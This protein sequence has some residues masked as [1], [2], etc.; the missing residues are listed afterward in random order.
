MFVFMFYVCFLIFKKLASNLGSC[1]IVVILDF[2]PL[3]QLLFYIFVILTSPQLFTLQL[4][5]YEQKS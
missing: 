4:E 5:I 1:I 2:L 3:E